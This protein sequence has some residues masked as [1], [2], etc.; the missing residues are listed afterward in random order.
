MT[1]CLLLGVLCPMLVHAGWVRR[2]TQECLG[3]F[4]RVH[5]ACD[6]GLGY[7]MVGGGF[8]G[9]SVWQG[10][11]CMRLGVCV[12]LSGLSPVS[13]GRGVEL[14]VTLSGHGL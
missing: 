11:V 2:V 10:F 6:C 3:W 4:P 7:L 1:L 12:S 13:A 5:Q 8:L 9:G 14:G